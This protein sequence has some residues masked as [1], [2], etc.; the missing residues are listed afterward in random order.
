MGLYSLYFTLPRALIPS[1]F[2]SV[3]IWKDP[4]SKIYFAQNHMFWVEICLRGDSNYFMP[5]F[6]RPPLQNVWN[7]LT[8]H[9]LPANSVA[10]RWWDLKLFRFKAVTCLDYTRVFY[11]L[12]ILSN[13]LYILSNEGKESLYFHYFIA[14][15]FIETVCHFSLL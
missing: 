12:P 5:Y 6:R 4:L 15:A 7:Q 1:V 8:L 9:N 11:W 14:T 10:Q 2:L 13:S 3:A